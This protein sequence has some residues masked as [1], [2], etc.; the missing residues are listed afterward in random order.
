MKLGPL[1]EAFFVT[2][3]ADTDTDTEV[4]EYTATAL[5]VVSSDGKTPTTG[6]PA[7]SGIRVRDVHV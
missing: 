2:P 6:S 3:L 5:D 4:E 1:G 7:T